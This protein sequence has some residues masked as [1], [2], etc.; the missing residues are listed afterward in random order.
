MKK[1]NFTLGNALLGCFLAMIEK[2]NH[3]LSYELNFNTFKLKTVLTE[4][5]EVF[6]S[7]KKSFFEKN[8]KGEL[9]KYHLMNG[10]PFAI[11]KEGE[12]IPDENVG[13]KVIESQQKQFDELV[14]KFNNDLFEFK[15][16]TLNQK[17][18][19]KAICL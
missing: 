8:E 9:N 5:L 7:A 17:E 16:K 12:P 11:V 14:E 2:E 18:L 19:K 1:I 6:E 13:Y 3:G 4:S 10:V 15:L